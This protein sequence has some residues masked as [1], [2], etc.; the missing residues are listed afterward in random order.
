MFL[1]K[2]S[3]SGAFFAM[4]HLQDHVFGADRHP[5]VGNAGNALDLLL[6]DRSDLTGSR[7]SPDFALQGG[8]FFHIFSIPK[9]KKHPDVGL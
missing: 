1:S 2:T 5:N 9:V 6:Q 4:S 3:A 7:W 8:V